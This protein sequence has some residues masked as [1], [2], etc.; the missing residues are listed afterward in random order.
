MKN[1]K[2]FFNC[3]FDDPRITTFRLITFGAD[4]LQR[5][6]VNNVGGIY[7]PIITLTTTC[8]V[9][10]ETEQGDIDHDF[11][12]QKVSTMAID[13][14]R[15][16]ILKD[17][18]LASSTVKVAFPNNALAYEE[19]FPL[20]LNE[21]H[22]S[23]RD[24]MYRLLVDFNKSITDHAANFTVAFAQTWNDYKTNYSIA[25]TLQTSKKAIV[26]GDRES[27]AAQ[28]R[29][30]ENQLMDN[31]YDLGKEYKRKLHKCK[32]FFN[33]SLL[34]VRHHKTD[35][36]ETFEGELMAGDTIVLTDEFENETLFRVTNK[37]DFSFML[38]F[39]DSETDACTVGM[40]ID[41]GETKE[42]TAHDLGTDNMK[43]V[44]LTNAN[45]EEKCIYEVIKFIA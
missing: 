43:Y 39:S 30:L 23:S 20:G 22:D 3:V 9:N 15:K 25:H 35:E 21:W 31:L 28:R 29:N 41:K 14:L 24:K 42:I 33:Q 26:S 32:V 13:M 2:G 19:F 5:L 6:I 34:F 36:K 11:I 27:F 17:I 38:C 16:D 4:H 8:L 7:T 40:V 10:I 18:S 37:G 45:E 1:L 12:L 44:K